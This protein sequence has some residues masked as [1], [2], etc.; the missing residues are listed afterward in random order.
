MGKVG[1]VQRRSGH[2][3]QKREDRYSKYATGIYTTD[4]TCPSCLSIS[5]ICLMVH[6]DQPD[7]SLLFSAAAAAQLAQQYIF[8]YKHVYTYLRIYV[9]KYID[10]T[11][12][13]VSCAL[14]VSIFYIGCCLLRERRQQ[15][16]LLQLNL[17]I[18]CPS[19]LKWMRAQQPPFAS[20]SLST[21]TGPPS[22]SLR[23]HRRRLLLLLL[24]I[25]VVYEMD[26][27]SFLF[28]SFFFFPLSLTN[29]TRVPELP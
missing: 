29:K 8:I 17:A 28:S 11:K 15:P 13:R 25:G 18:K 4:K 10:A 2:P 16:G 14:R 3:S 26:D 24:F 21:V 5:S 12:V 1:I 20:V 7:T 19:S 9:N 27:G 23:R 22:T 6:I